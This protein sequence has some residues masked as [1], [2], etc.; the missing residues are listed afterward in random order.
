M[1]WGEGG[2]NIPESTTAEPCNI[3]DNTT[4]LGNKSGSPQ[5]V[6]RWPSIYESECQPGAS[7]TRA[8]VGVF[9][10]STG[11]HDGQRVIRLNPSC[12]WNRGIVLSGT[13]RRV[14]RFCPQH[15]NREISVTFAVGTRQ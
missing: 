10:L 6:W 1:R 7:R 8:G 3:P 12:Y 5:V 15:A 11:L 14:I 4:L 9:D 2:R 13:Q